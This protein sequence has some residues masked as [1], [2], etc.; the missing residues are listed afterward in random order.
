MNAAAFHLG[1][2][3]EAIRVI[4]TATPFISM[5]QRSRCA[6]H[7]KRELPHDFSN[8]AGLL[9]LGQ[10]TFESHCS[11]RVSFPCTEALTLA[12][13]SDLRRSGSRSGHRY[14]SERTTTGTLRHASASRGFGDAQGAVQMPLQNEDAGAGREVIVFR[15][16]AKHARKVTQHQQLANAQRGFTAAIDLARSAPALS[17]R[18]A[19]AAAATEARCRNL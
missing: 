12:V 14:R 19:A 1:A 18:T 7:C 17:A 11:C 4:H 2:V 16:H 8:E 13:R 15:F 3:E 9:P 5:T 10:V 6:C